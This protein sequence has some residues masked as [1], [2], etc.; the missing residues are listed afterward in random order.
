MRRVG[1]V[2]SDDYQP[3]SPRS[4]YDMNRFTPIC[5]SGYK[6]ALASF[7]VVMMFQ[8]PA[9]KQRLL[10]FLYRQIVV[11]PFLVGMF[12]QIVLASS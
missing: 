1:D 8:N 12:G 3:I 5:K 7:R 6:A 10:N 9:G 11:I 4:T 2:D